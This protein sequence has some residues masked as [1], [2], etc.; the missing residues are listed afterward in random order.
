METLVLG[1]RYRTDGVVSAVPVLG[2]DEALA[3][4]RRFELAETQL[5]PLHYRDKIHTV[6]TSPWELATHPTVLECVA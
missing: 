2:S 4:R 1:E 5:G 6:L 3:H